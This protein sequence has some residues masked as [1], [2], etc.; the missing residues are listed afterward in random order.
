MGSLCFYTLWYNEELDYSRELT[1]ENIDRYLDDHQNGIPST[2]TKNMDPTHQKC[3]S[4]SSLR[5]GLQ[6]HKL[7]RV[8]WKI[9]QALI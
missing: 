4:I 1:R 7:G 3:S 9:G 2:L 5:V 8:G 6:H